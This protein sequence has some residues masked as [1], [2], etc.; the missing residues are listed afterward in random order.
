[1]HMKKTVMYVLAAVLCLMFAG[2]FA[3]ENT[4]LD[5]SGEYFA[6]DME[7]VNGTLYMLAE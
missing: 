2:A 5:H 1:M 6:M 7:A 3:L 4:V